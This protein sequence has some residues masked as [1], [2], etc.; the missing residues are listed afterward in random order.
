LKI[1]G[2][3]GGIGSGKTTI[4]NFFR[5]LGVPVY[6][7]DIEAKILMHEDETIVHELVEL[8][9]QEVYKNQKLNSAFISDRVFKDKDLLEKLN[10]IVHPKV[11]VHFNNW[12]QSQTAN[13]CV[14]EA[15]I[16]FET[17]G[18]KKCDLIILVTAPKKIRIERVM[19]RD[20]TSL[21]AVESRMANQW[22]DKEKIVLAD[23]VIENHDLKSSKAQVAKIHETLTK[24][25]T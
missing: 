2:L 9:G 19:K 6:I 4:T 13:Y 5:D 15:A 21:S 18:Y 7:A 3:T 23:F 11:E 16:L 8:F 10:R 17:G 1:I 24:Y 22:K 25:S 12:V 14:K 20:N